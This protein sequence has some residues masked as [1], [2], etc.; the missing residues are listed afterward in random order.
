M[1][2]KVISY[3]NSYTNACRLVFQS[4][5]PIIHK[6]SSVYSLNILNDLKRFQSNTADA[7]FKEPETINKVQSAFRCSVNDP[8]N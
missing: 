3:R 7:P 1:F 2:K 4:A 6:N 5:N 8:V